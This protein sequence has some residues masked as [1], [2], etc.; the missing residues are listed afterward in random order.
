M[1]NFG[2]T[3]IKKVKRAIYVRKHA[4]E[5]TGA[6]VGDSWDQLD[7]F[8]KSTATPETSLVKYKESDYDVSQ[9]DCFVRLGEMETGVA[10]RAED[11]DTVTTSMLREVLL[12]ENA[13]FEGTIIHV[14]KANYEELRSLVKNNNVDILMVDPKSVTTTSSANGIGM[15]DVTLRALPSFGEDARDTISLSVNEECGNVDENLRYVDVST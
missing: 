7:G 14:T 9:D 1:Y 13:V 11:G 15:A 5:G 10:M 8:I 3:N 2:N 4:E 6:W 12:S